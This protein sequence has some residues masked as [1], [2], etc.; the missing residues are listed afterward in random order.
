M[1]GAG[2]TE[3][4]DA[5]QP[6]FYPGVRQKVYAVGK[7]TQY[8][9]EGDP[10]GP[11]CTKIR[12]SKTEDKSWF[13]SPMLEE[14]CGE[15]KKQGI[16]ANVQAITIMPSH[17]VDRFSPTLHRVAVDLSKYLG[18]PYAQCI[19]RIKEGRAHHGEKLDVAGR[20]LNTVN[21]MKVDEMKFNPAWKKIIIL[22]DVKA[23]GI[24]I[25][26]ARRI[27]LGTGVREVVPICFAINV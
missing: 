22:D 26:E 9:G 19:K 27:L 25:L 10:N 4:E 18:I 11:F 24:S 20:Y 12:Y 8:Q 16:L 13:F 1:E 21:S 5:Y 6:D 7:Y 17:S 23:S 15:L 14:V 3:T 2:H